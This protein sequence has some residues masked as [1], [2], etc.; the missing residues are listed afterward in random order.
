M[1]SIGAPRSFVVTCTLAFGV[2]TMSCQNPIEPGTEWVVGSWSL[3]RIQECPPPWSFN[4]SCHTTQD[5]VD[6]LTRVLSL[7]HDGRAMVREFGVVTQET[8][9][10]TGRDRSAAGIPY[11]LWFSE[12]ISGVTHYSLSNGPFDTLLFARPRTEWREGSEIRET[13]VRLP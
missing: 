11:T 7:E 1:V 9:F 2:L 10:R 5:V 4:P 12:Q 6:P 8:R 3:T 13:F